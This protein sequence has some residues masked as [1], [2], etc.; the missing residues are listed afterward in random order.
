MDADNT[1]VVEE[2]SIG[3]IDPLILFDTYKLHVNFM[4]LQPISGELSYLSLKIFHTLVRMAQAY[5][6]KHGDCELFKCSLGELMR[7][8]E[9][10]SHSYMVFKSAMNALLL[11]TVN[12]QSPT[13]DECPP[14]KHNNLLATAELD[15]LTP[16]SNSAWVFTWGFA[17]GIRQKI[18]YPERYGEIPYDEQMQLSKYSSFALHYNCIRY[19]SS[20][21]QLTPNK[22]WEDWAVILTGKTKAQVIKQGYRYFKNKILKP[23]IAQVNARTSVDILMLE[24]RSVFDGRK[25]ELL[26]FKIVEKEPTQKHIF[27]LSED[28]LPF[29]AAALNLG[30]KQTVAENLLQSYGAEKLRALLKQFEKRIG[31]IDKYGPINDP[32]AWLKDKA[33]RM[34]KEDTHLIDFTEAKRR[35]KREEN[36]PKLKAEWKVIFGQRKNAET[37]AEIEELPVQE[38]EHWIDQFRESIKDSTYKLKMLEREGWKNPGVKFDFVDFYGRTKYGENWRTPTP[39][40]LLDIAAENG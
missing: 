25:A 14:W 15:R 38:Q 7:M 5:V 18:L 4:A 33:K 1:L 2:R 13:A 3:V 16:E 10:N 9:F 22:P 40:E 35:K 27:E 31:T 37:I 11:T 29:I 19:I 21:S 30:I 17:P 24:K 20:S 8:T 6:R 12:F 26:Q 28:D 34:A 39:E 23:A 32:S 36:I